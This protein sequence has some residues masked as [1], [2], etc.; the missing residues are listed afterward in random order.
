M[1]SLSFKAQKIDR[2]GTP[3]E[4]VQ[5][6][7]DLATTVLEIAQT[8]FSNRKP[9][10]T[11]LY[12]VTAEDVHVVDAPLSQKENERI[13]VGNLTI[14]MAHDLFAMGVATLSE[15]WLIPG[16]T[17]SDASERRPNTPRP[18]RSSSARLASSRQSSTHW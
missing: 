3:F 11:S 9:G 2:A 10:T 18:A 8:Q 1:S 13:A 4:E 12:F 16:A 7:R 14:K 15:A 5:G 17:E 6:A